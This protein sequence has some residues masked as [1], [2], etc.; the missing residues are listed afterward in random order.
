MSKPTPPTLYVGNRVYSSWSIRPFLV[1]R[2]SGIEFDVVD[3]DL[4]QDGYG[5]KQI[6]EVL[7]ISPTGTVPVLK[8]N[9]LII[10]DSLAIAEY[11]AELAP[12]AQLW[13]KDTAKRAIARALTCEMHSGFGAIRN[14]LGHNLKRRIKEQDWDAET[15]IEIKRL[16]D[17]FANIPEQNGGKYLFGDTPTIADAFF[18][19]IASRFRTYDVTIS[20]KASEYCQTLL[21][22]PAWLEWEKTALDTWKPFMAAPWDSLYGDD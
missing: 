8:H 20:N 17:I 14:N 21:N 7:E 22:D 18:T 16:D 1:L 4:D 11:I 19:P 2:Y 3:I 12:D 9:D 6:R 10:W 15:R 13:P 5:K